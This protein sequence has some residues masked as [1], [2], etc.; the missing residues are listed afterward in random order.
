MYDVVIHVAGIVHQPKCQDATLYNRVNTEMPICIAEKFKKSRISKSVFVF[1]S[2]MA[3][4]GVS[5]RLGRNVIYEDTATSPAGL[6]GKSKLSA[7][8]GLL[9]LQDDNFDVII[10]I[11]IDIRCVAVTKTMRSYTLYPKIGTYG[12]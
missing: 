10:V 2:T 4:F 12:F 1:L 6:Y 7:E 8:D 3:V 11:H 9:P 5:K